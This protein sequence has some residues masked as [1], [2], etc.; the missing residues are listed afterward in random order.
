[1]SNV[2]VTPIMKAAIHSLFY[3]HRLSK[4]SISRKVGVHRKT[5][6]RHL[7]CGRIEK[8][9]N[10]IKEFIDN[11]LK[12]LGTN[13]K[14]RLGKPK[15]DEERRES[16]GSDELPPRGTG[17]KKGLNISL[18]PIEM[19]SKKNTESKYNTKITAT[20]EDKWIEAAKS[21]L[22]DAK[23]NVDPVIGKP[24]VNNE[25]YN[26]EPK[27]RAEERR[28]IDLAKELIADLLKGKISLKPGQQAPKG[29]RTITGPK[30]GKYYESGSGGGEDKKPSTREAGYKD[31]T[32]NEKDGANK[33]ARQSSSDM[34][35]WSKYYE[36]KTKRSASNINNKKD[37][38]NFV[39]TNDLKNSKES[40]SKEHKDEAI[41]E[42]LTTMKKPEI[43]D[44]LSTLS[45]KP[46]KELR[47][48]QDLIESQMKR[49]NEQK[50]TKAIKN[51]EIRGEMLIGAINIREFGDKPKDFVSH[52]NSTINRV[53][54]YKAKDAYIPPSVA[55]AVIDSLFA[56]GG[57][58]AGAIPVG[59]KAPPKGAR[60]ITGPKGGKYYLIGGDNKKPNS[61]SNDPN[62]NN[63]N[64]SSNEKI[65]IEEI[66]E[67]RTKYKRQEKGKGKTIS[68]TTER[69][70][71]VVLKHTKYGIISGGRNPTI[72]DDKALSDEQIIQRNKQ[73][74][75]DLIDSGYQFLPV[76][77]KYGGIEDSFLI[78][79][80]DSDKKELTDL[81]KKY[82][83]DSV[84]HVD[85]NKNEMIF[86]TG[87]NVGKSHV[88]DEFSYVPKMNDNFTEVP[89]GGK[90][91]KYALNFDFGNTVTSKAQDSYSPSSE[92]NAPNYEDDE[93]KK[94]KKGLR[95]TARALREGKWDEE[96]REWITPKT[97]KEDKKKSVCETM[98]EVWDR[99]D[100]KESTKEIIFAK[101]FRPGW[102]LKL[103]P[104]GS[105]NGIRK[106][107]FRLNG[108]FKVISKSL[109]KI[110]DA[111]NDDIIVAGYASTEIKDAQNESISKE[112]MK[113][114][115]DRWIKNKGYANCMI[116]HKNLQ[117][118]DGI[119]SVTI[120]G[121]IYKTHFDDKGFF[122]V[123]KMRTDD[124]K[125]IQDA[126]ND[127]L[128][129][130]L[131]SYS[132]GG[133][134]IDE[135]QV[136]TPGEGC[137][138]KITKLDLWEVS[139]CEKGVNPESDFKV[140]VAPAS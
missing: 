46:L 33:F 52:I 47:R 37:F 72:P 29:A 126:R 18:K 104:S 67:V 53:K 128:N 43:V 69:E 138:N 42:D 21:V 103:T 137:M 130:V 111:Q 9:N 59:N 15:T 73:L 62:S 71:D 3:D 94:N 86:T 84:I 93:D 63:N 122:L 66:T 108:E 58:P 135:G 131:K 57:I 89:V 30:G 102:D 139:Y 100:G 121:A 26:Q 24:K 49:A 22:K 83:Q 125:G 28:R 7:E 23:I 116:K 123:S 17:K 127:V 114:A 4:G 27:L 60:T 13:G 99:I 55:K 56:K 40:E 120:D 132:I 129:G 98:Q 10:E 106:E 115:F 1:L 97:V 101:E 133:E 92:T 140:L 36:S 39:A 118:A 110:K 117:I 32:Q 11:I 20:G 113:E 109:D 79:V 76:V 41:G 90:K 80:Q 45:K 44:N 65:T 34:Q 136:C 77:G 82:N 19:P 51:L 87:E 95:G 96:R 78:M 54:T 2:K 12:G 91:I 88:G 119:D 16:H 5:V 31:F 14:P 48:R 107:S 70:L 85:N 8:M 81:G 134:A 124:I 25:P 68:F 74:H 64:I 61:V 50:N 6:H 105:G 112:A 75:N 35:R 38:Y